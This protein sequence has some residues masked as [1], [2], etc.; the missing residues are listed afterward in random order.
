M[1]K[2]TK[3]QQLIV[4]ACQPKRGDI[5]GT[6][7]DRVISEIDRQAGTPLADT[8]RWQDMIELV[9]VLSSR[10]KRHRV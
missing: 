7:V 9:Q 2:L 10:R 3:N 6:A 1:S 4:N 8:A 5:Y